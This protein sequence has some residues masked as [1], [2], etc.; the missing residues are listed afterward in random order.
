MLC[1][2]RD[3]SKPLAEMLMPE[4]QNLVQLKVRGLFGR[5]DYDLPIT[6]TDSPIAILTAPNGYGKTHL[7]HMIDAL[8]R[9]DYLELSRYTFDSL[10]IQLA[11]QS[12]MTVTR[13]NMEGNSGICRMDLKERSLGKEQE[14]RASVAVHPQWGAR[15]ESEETDSAAT[16]WPERRKEFRN[17]TDPRAHVPHWVQAWHQRLQR[18][19]MLPSVRLPVQSSMWAEM[20]G[21]PEGS[22]LDAVREQ[23]QRSVQQSLKDYAQTVREHERNLP[24]SLLQALQGT[25]EVST[26]ELRDLFGRLQEQERC[27]E[28][29]QLISPG[30]TESI[31]PTGANYLAEQGR[32][33]RCYCENILERF[34]TLQHCSRRLKLLLDT[35]NLWLHRKHFQTDSTGQLELRVMDRNGELRQPLSLDK[36]SSGEQQLV[37]LLGLLIFDTQPKQLVLLDEPELSLHPAWQDDFLPLLQQICELN[38]CYLLMATH[39]PSLVGDDWNIVCE[40]ADQVEN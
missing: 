9:Q 15:W 4:P 28:E 34:H 26:E 37:Y 5:F 31:L 21:M 6:R 36:L 11:D 29:L 2:I 30:T 33:L 35:L 23:I 19:S 12:Q 24:Q 1:V 13:M 18:V 32:L 16:E 8:A 39:S 17:P 14:Q 27:L 3:S 22:K 20:G 40:L 38:G 25:E 7:L 10:E